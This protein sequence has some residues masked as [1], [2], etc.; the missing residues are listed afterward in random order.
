MYNLVYL[1]R[2]LL[3][4]F[5]KMH[6]KISS[7]QGGELWDWK[8]V[9]ESF[10][11]HRGLPVGYRTPPFRCTL[12]T[13][14]GAY[15]L[16]EKA[17]L[18]INYRHCRISALFPTRGIWSLRDPFIRT[19][20]DFPTILPQN[21]TILIYNCLLLYIASL[22]SRF[23]KGF[24]SKKELRPSLVNASLR[25]SQQDPISLNQCLSREFYH[26]EFFL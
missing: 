1:K 20:T 17:D 24:Q 11:I 19:A 15:D 25:N 18:M 13:S 5:E 8:E 9:E 6:L 4:K 12:V 26:L 10:A 23:R 16:R 14:I 3:E 21:A 22:A 7:K 2:C